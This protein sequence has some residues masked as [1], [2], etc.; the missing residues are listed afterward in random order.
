MVSVPFGYFL[1]ATKVTRRRNRGQRQNRH[2]FKNI[3]KFSKS[4][5][6]ILLYQLFTQEVP[7]QGFF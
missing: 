2:S 3:A 4:I 6:L 5:I 1:G 7:P